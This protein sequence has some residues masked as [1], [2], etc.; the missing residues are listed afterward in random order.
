MCAVG[1]KIPQQ[2]TSGIDTEG[3]DNGFLQKIL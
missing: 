3:E 2:E 1:V